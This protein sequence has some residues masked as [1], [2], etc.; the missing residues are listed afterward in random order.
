MA[1]DMDGLEEVERR[2]NE[3]YRNRKIVSGFMKDK[4][5]SRV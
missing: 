4:V 5:R 2:W 3:E 1:H